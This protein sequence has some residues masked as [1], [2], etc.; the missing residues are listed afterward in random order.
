M[1]MK[2]AILLGVERLWRFYR[3]CLSFEYKLTG[4]EVLHDDGRKYK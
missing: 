2:R 4:D 1:G 3:G